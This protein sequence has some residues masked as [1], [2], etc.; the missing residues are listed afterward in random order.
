LAQYGVWSEP[1]TN[2]LG[3]AIQGA[4]VAV[5]NGSAEPTTVVPCGGSSLAT[6]YSSF[7]GGAQTN[8]LYTD[9]N[10][11]AF[12]YAVPGSYYLQVYG[13]GLQT[14]VVP[15]TIGTAIP[16]PPALVT[17]SVSNGLVV[18]TN[19]QTGNVIDSGTD[20]AAVIN[21]VLNAYAAAGGTLYFINGTYDLNSLTQESFNSSGSG[22]TFN[23]TNYYYGIGIPS[24]YPSANW[25]QWH[26]VAEQRPPRVFDYTETT[27]N[28]AGVIF[29]VTPTAISS[30]SSGNVAVCMWQRPVAT[31][32]F[33][34]EIYVDGIDCRFPT[35][36]RGNEVGFGFPA[37]GS[38]ELDNFL[39]DFNLSYDAIYNGSTPAAGSFGVET[40]FGG[41]SN[42][43]ILKDGQS[44]GYQY[45]YDF[46]GEHING[47]DIGG[48]TCQ[49][50]MIF[51]RSYP[52]AT[53]H[54]NVLTHFI[55]Q[56][57][58]N[59]PVLNEQFGTHIDFINYDIEDASSG[60]PFARQ[61]YFTE[62]TPGNTSG[63]LT[64]TAVV[65]N[66]GIL[67]IIPFS[68]VAIVNTGT[69]GSCGGSGTAVC[70]V[71]GP[72][73]TSG[74]AGNYVDIAGAWYKVSTYN[75]PTSITLTSSAGNQTS[76]GFQYA[77]GGGVDFS[78]NDGNGWHCCGLGS[79]PYPLGVFPA[80]SSGATGRHVYVS[81]ATAQTWGATVSGGGSDYVEAACDGSNY[82]TVAK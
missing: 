10:G 58:Q 52:A 4:T 41:S 13:T 8:P 5:C 27:I 49:Y 77:P 65:Q 63:I 50:A 81:D 38:L 57:N 39:A 30:I 7:S 70:L 51:S 79:G 67:G 31:T 54:P 72:S 62:N 17:F 15:I 37:A 40:P 61:S 44:V 22:I 29:Y 9:A 34:N 47:I 48:Q 2:T 73:F 3:Q 18:A 80:C 24:N 68:Q 69:G 45:C 43:T 42:T 12:V 59:G 75:S 1:V 23:A 64:Y 25:V 35:N 21:Y 6:I 36:T 56:E 19:S 16:A 28:N 20:A 55:D 71:S 33:A 11:H 14:Q 74:M 76:A 78:V 66:V 26:F 60:T 53:Y 82:T 46:Q 32:L